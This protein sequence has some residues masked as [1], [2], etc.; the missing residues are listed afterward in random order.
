MNSAR[1][2]ETAWSRLSLFLALSLSFFWAP[3]SFAVDDSALLAAAERVAVGG[4]NPSDEA[5]LF[6][7]NRR[8]NHLAMEGKLDGSVYQRTQS[9]YDERN[10]SLAAEAAREAGFSTVAGGRKIYKPGTDTD[11][12][13]TGRDLTAAD[14]EFARQAYN[15]RVEAYLRD[16]GL[17][18]ERGV[19]WAA[20]TETDIMPSPSQMKSGEEF[21]KAAAIINGD[22]GNMYSSP[23]AAGAQAKL[24]A[25]DPVSI[26]EGL[27][28]AEEMKAKVEKMKQVKS[29]LA[30]RYRGAGTP[31]EREF[32]AAEI[33]KAESHEAKY[34]DRINRL[35]RN[36]RG[37]VVAEPSPLLAAAGTRTPDG[38]SR[39]AEAAVDAMSGHLTEKAL[40]N[41]ADTLG[42]LAA[43]S[44]SPERRAALKEAMAATL[45]GLPPARQDDALVGIESR[46]GRGFA[47]EVS[48]EMK[49]PT[50]GV[51]SAPSGSSL[52]RGAGIVS[53]LLAGYNVVAEENRRT[54]GNPDYGRVALNFVYDMTLRGAVDAAGRD[55]AEFTEK[56]VEELGEYYRSRGEDPESFAT[57]L[58]ILAEASLKGTAY[59]TV[60]GTYE[61]AKASGKWAGGAIV[62]GA[63]TVIFLG[64]EALDTLNTLEVTGANLREQGM[65]QEVQDAKSVRSGR[66]LV[67]E[68][69][70]MAALAASQRSVL[71][72]NSRWG[73]SL[74]INRSRSLDALRGLIDGLSELPDPSDAEQ[75][76]TETVKRCL[77]EFKRIAEYSSVIYSKIKA[78]EKALSGGKSAQDV[79]DD[80]R[81]IMTEHDGNI[82]GFN[83]LVEE[84]KELRR[85]ESLG[86]VGDIMA[87]LRED[88]DF[89]SALGDKAEDG[90]VIMKR[91]YDT[92]RRA[93]YEFDRIKSS[94]ARGYSYF[95]GKRGLPGWLAIKSDADSIV[96]PDR[97]IPENGGVELAT[98]QRMKSSIASD[99]ERMPRVNVDE[100]RLL[101][102]LEEVKKGYNSLLPEYG[103]ARD[104]L[105][106][107]NLALEKLIDLLGG[108]PVP[109]TPESEDKG[110]EA[111]FVAGGETGRFGLRIPLGL[112]DLLLE[113]TGLSSVTE[114]THK[115]REDV[116]NG[117]Y[118]T[119]EILNTD[120]LIVFLTPDKREVRISLKGAGD[121]PDPGSNKFLAIAGTIAYSKEKSVVGYYLDFKNNKLERSPQGVYDGIMVMNYAV[122]D[123]KTTDDTEETLA[124]HSASLGL[125]KG[126]TQETLK[127][128][129]VT[130]LEM[131][132]FRVS[133][134]GSGDDNGGTTI[135]GAVVGDFVVNVSFNRRSLRP[136]QWSPPSFD[137]DKVVF[138]LLEQIF[139]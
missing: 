74:D 27:A 52:L 86:Q 81:F 10:R 22:G 26:A 131:G 39:R 100:R 82:D 25:G 93:V 24:D 64:G 46:L 83:V 77:P 103:A 56:Q 112:N 14:V 33:R 113:K 43:S 90:A 98:L 36:L 109:Q 47:R 127:G 19:N 92:W 57:K 134:R 69:R 66:E 51:K 13:M 49:K 95:Y 138:L 34:I 119:E 136:E 122:I 111:P 137:Q 60:K 31:Q 78:V 35:E 68:L 55:T 9:L 40:R 105:E 73:R 97:T 54:S 30:E 84:M 65:A 32:L 102:A 4:G 104:S 99:L 75:R 58:K 59:G 72:Q 125:G 23:F 67:G 118:L 89:I 41:Y 116:E 88:R 121:L 130:V 124:F 108:I 5:L 8:V 50:R 15:K 28:Y 53:T 38:A 126:M 3:P 62:G 12:N 48:T 139:P 117:Y 7:E 70:R 76:T 94:L 6:M 135:Y 85:M 96:A 44:A 79:A 16:S 20:R 1:A 115:Q 37:G 71:E 101:S 45:K 128:M 61:L 110:E 106:K 2:R 132:R 63:E 133:K 21:A 17:M 42:D 87:S 129:G 29:D 120:L 114:G 11:V 107:T 80:V 91:N 18:A 123:A